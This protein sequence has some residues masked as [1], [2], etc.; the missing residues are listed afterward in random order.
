MPR[1]ERIR[2]RRD[3]LAAARA[4]KWVSGGLIL[5]MRRR[6]PEEP[7]T[8][9]EAARVGFTA[10]RKIGGAVERNRAK[11]R[12]RAAAAQVLA[13][14][15]GAGVDYVLIAR[16]EVTL[17]RPYAALLTDLA[18]ALRRVESPPRAKDSAKGP[19]SGPKGEGGA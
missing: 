2:H 8:T 11:R 6:A 9:P 17:E 18:E 1:L 16:P 4:R 13:E 15:A 7:Q 12:L 14:G 5:Q 19:P 3:F 10:S